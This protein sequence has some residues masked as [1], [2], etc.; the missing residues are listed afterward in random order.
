MKYIIIRV[1]HYELEN[2]FKVLSLSAFDIFRSGYQKYF[3]KTGHQICI[4]KFS[5]T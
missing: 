4:S 3:K 5:I 2:N 1:P